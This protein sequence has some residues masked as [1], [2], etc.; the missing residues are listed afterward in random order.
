VY[1]G[2]IMTDDNDNI[3]P[4]PYGEIRNPIIEPRR[5]DEMDMAGE[6]IQDILM[7]LSE[8]GYNPKFDPAFF[9]DMGCILNL[10]YGA[11][12]RNENPNYPFVEILDIIHE[13]IMETRNKNDDN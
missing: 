11:L 2:D 9:R 13:M 10:I 4:F 12:V 1:N 8:Y 6:C 3:I 5:D 7:T